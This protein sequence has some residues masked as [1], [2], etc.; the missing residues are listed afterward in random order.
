[1]K[2]TLHV[3]DIPVRGSAAPVLSHYTD[4]RWIDPASPGEV[5]ISTLAAKALVLAHRPS[6]QQRL[7]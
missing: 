5:G 4:A 6:A 2:L 1:M 3:L 7:L